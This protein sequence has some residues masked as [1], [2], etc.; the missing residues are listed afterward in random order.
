MST[1]RVIHRWDKAGAPTQVPGYA[2]NIEGVSRAAKY[3]KAAGYVG[4]GLATAAASMRIN[5]VC[6]AGADEP[7]RKVKYIEG[8]KLTGN[9]G[10]AAIATTYTAPITMEYRAGVALKTRG[11]GG[12]ICVLVISGAAASLGG[13]AGSKGVEST[14]EV[15]YESSTHD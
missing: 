11:I 14:A 12:V 5:E 4:I 15:L 6:R 2:T 1:R 10:G 13:N 9:V 7:C 8:A 3:M